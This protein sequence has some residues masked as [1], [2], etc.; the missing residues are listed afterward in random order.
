M[1]RF[2]P[3]LISCCV[4]FVWLLFF[5]D[6]FS[7]NE[8]ISLLTRVKSMNGAVAESSSCISKFGF[9]ILTPLMYISLP[10]I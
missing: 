4:T 10:F 5:A 6:S 7:D 9:S 8:T 1:M 3:S 2:L